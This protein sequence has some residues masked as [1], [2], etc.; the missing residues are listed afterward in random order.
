MSATALWGVYTAR[1]PFLGVDL[2]KIRPVVVLS[3]P[4][5]RH[6][7]IT[8]VPLSLKD[9]KE[10]VDIALRDWREAGLIKPSVARIHRMTT[11][12]QSDL[13]GYLGELSAADKPSLQQALRI[14]LNL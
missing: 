14:L 1:F 3:K 13:I 8:V 11:I 7:I 10:S 6:N 2:G 12:L 4:Y 9:K 5:G